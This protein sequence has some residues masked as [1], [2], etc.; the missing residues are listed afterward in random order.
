MPELPPEAD[1]SRPPAARVY[2]YLTGG[3]SN[4]AADRETA[5]PGAGHG[6][7]FRRVARKP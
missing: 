6:D 3:K 4:F 5:A 1:P 2:D 7:R